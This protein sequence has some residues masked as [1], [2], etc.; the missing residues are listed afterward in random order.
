MITEKVIDICVVMVQMPDLV[1]KV[2]RRG[3]PCLEIKL[4]GELDLPRW[5]GCQGISETALAKLQRSRLGADR[6]E[7]SKQIIYMVEHVE[8]FRAEFEMFLFT[9]GELLYQRRIPGLVSG[10]LDD[11]ASGVAESSQYRVIGKRAGVK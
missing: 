2:R 11:V 9:D 8:E 1:P 5:P 3:A 7:L 10:T 4:Q 6:A